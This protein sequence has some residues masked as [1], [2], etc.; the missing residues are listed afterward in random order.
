MVVQQL[1]HLGAEEKE[2]LLFYLLDSGPVFKDVNVSQHVDDERSCETE[3]EEANQLKYAV[4]VRIKGK[5]RMMRLAGDKFLPETRATFFF[6]S[7]RPSTFFLLHF[8][9][10]SSSLHS[11]MRKYSIHHIT[12]LR[13]ISSDTRSLQSVVIIIL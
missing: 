11:G 12:R 7:D 5:G 4:C 10:L 3:R 9:P 1:R 13:F 8:F 6:L 2:L